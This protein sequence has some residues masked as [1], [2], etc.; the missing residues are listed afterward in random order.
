VTATTSFD[1]SDDDPITV[2]RI[3]P[4]Q[5]PVLRRLRLRS[6]ADAPD[7][8]GQPLE[9]AMG[10]PA[11]E[12]ARVAAAA[13][14]GDQRAWYLAFAGDEPVGLVQGRRRR[15]ATLL[16]FSMWV[17]PEARR[18]HVGMRLIETLEGW[19]RGWGAIETVLWVIR[20]NA[21]ALDFY[22]V[23]GF[24][25]LTEGPDAESGAQH[26]AV[27]LRRLIGATDRLSD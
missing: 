19:A 1:A 7:A 10:R 14:S 12:W 13:A 25:I 22:G 2:T 21:S 11:A 3:D 9:E 16:L 15:P 18:R 27:A 6:L 8:F 26:S 23:L 24:D 5:G 20:G 17:A 4:S